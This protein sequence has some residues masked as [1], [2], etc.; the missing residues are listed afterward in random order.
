M[1]RN[2]TIMYTLQTAT[3]T[4]A[5]PWCASQVPAAAPAGTYAQS[6]HLR[7]PANMTQKSLQGTQLAAQAN[8]GTS[9]LASQTRHWRQQ[10]DLNQQLQTYSLTSSQATTGTHGM[11]FPAH[12]AQAR[13]HSLTVPP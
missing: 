6:K 4:K 9:C 3:I 2:T 1:F 11:S 12:E 10:A 7:P 13:R 8:H 5:S